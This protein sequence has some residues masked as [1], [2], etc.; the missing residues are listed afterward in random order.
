MSIRVDADCE[1]STTSRPAKV[2]VHWKPEVKSQ[3]ERAVVLGVIEPVPPDTAVT[4]LHNMVVL[5]PKPDEVA[6][7][8][9]GSTDPE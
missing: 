3:L 8:N 9:C 6:P 7:P 1:P 5:T 4:W 2:P